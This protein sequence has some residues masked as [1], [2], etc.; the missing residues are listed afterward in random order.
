MRQFRRIRSMAVVGLVAASAMTGQ[1]VVQASGPPIPRELVGSYYVHAGG[2]T[3]R[4]NGVVKVTYQWYFKRDH[5]LPSFPRL[6]L[7]VRSVRGNVL[8]GKVTSETEAL[9]GV[10]RKF[11]AKHVAPGYEL[12]FAGLSRV[13]RFCDRAHQA[14]GACGA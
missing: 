13:W 14:A 11:T 4:K 10:G 5:G 2:M 3:V 8:R 6:S 12:H 7:K 1:T 9:V